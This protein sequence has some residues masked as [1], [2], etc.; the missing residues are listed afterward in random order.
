MYGRD[1][2]RVK[3]LR[4]ESGAVVVQVT[5]ELDLCSSHVF[6]EQLLSALE[7]GASPLVIDLS[8]LS[9]IDSTG[10]GVLAVLARRV[11]LEA[12]E[13]ALVCPEG[14][15]R[16]TL[17]TTGLQRTIPVYPTREEALADRVR[18]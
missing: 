12:T 8:E 1:D 9:L 16:G 7:S 15:I 5:G 13:L 18:S 6:R 10:L 3:H 14:R 4:L 17:K 11:T 2:F